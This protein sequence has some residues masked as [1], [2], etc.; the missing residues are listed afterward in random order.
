[1]S[2]EKSSV[3]ERS[4]SAWFARASESVRCNSSFSCARPVPTD[5]AH[6][7]SPQAAGTWC[8]PTSRENHITCPM[9]ASLVATSPQAHVSSD[10]AHAVRAASP[11]SLRGITACNRGLCLGWSF[12]QQ[13]G[14]TSSLG[15]VIQRVGQ[16]LSFP[17]GRVLGGREQVRCPGAAATLPLD[18]YPRPVRTAL[19]CPVWAPD[20]HSRLFFALSLLREH[21]WV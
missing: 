5:W 1:M 19:V 21:S 8:H 20:W 9:P 18:L 2:R 3:F 6:A 12:S 14:G 16:Y 15:T 13:P 10:S 4:S 17:H 7:P 11:R